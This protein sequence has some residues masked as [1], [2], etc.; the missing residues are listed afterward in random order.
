M[1]TLYKYRAQQTRQENGFINGVII[2]NDAY[3]IGANRSKILNFASLIIFG[4]VMAAVAVHIVFRLVVLK[5]K[6]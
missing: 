6:S 2:D 4:L 5:K 1:G 3:V